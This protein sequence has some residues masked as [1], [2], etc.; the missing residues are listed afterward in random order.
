MDSTGDTYTALL[1]QQREYWKKK[2]E[3]TMYLS[4]KLDDAISA[5]TDDDIK[6]Y[7]L[8][9]GQTSQNVTRQDLPALI[10]RREKYDKQIEEIEKKLGIDIEP[11]R[12]HFFQGVPQW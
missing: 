3:R 6:S 11:E 5:L 2:L 9:T 10:D 1:E 7:S 12:P 4:N 8:D